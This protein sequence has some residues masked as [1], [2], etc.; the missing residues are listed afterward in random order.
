MKIKNI[1]FRM[2]ISFLLVCS[3]LIIGI[4]CLW[5]GMIP[6]K[7]SVREVKYNPDNPSEAILARNKQ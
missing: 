5:F 4:V 2:I 6:E 3:V 1:N 7:N